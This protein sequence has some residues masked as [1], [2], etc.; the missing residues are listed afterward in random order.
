MNR[1]FS[2]VADDA[3]LPGL[4][5]TIHSI[6]RF[7]VEP[8][9][10]Y[11]KMNSDNTEKLK[12]FA[13][14]YDDVRISDVSQFKV[15]ENGHMWTYKFQAM[16][17]CK[18]DVVMMLD[19]DQIITFY[20]EN[21]FKIAE[22]GFIRTCNGSCLIKDHIS[23]MAHKFPD[24]AGRPA[25]TSGSIC[26]NKVL[27]RDFFNR[28]CQ[29]YENPEIRPHIYGDMGAFLYTIC[30]FDYF[31][32]LHYESNTELVGTIWNDAQ[33]TEYLREKK[34]FIRKYDHA[35]GI[36]SM[37]H[38]NGDKPWMAYNTKRWKDNVG[39]RLENL[40]SLYLWCD[41]WDEVKQKTGVQVDL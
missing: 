18:E 16:M 33:G 7:H 28:V 22:Y 12:R 2:M 4:M 11:V 8:I 35:R 23:G 3:Y 36:I 21:W 32:H 40:D 24:V 39:L 14:F 19:V 6:R 15:F 34:L 9:Y 5:A 31:K 41:I 13:S 17:A 27:H 38:Y 10:A 26:A 1:C 37:V 25:V 30:E 29:N 20:V